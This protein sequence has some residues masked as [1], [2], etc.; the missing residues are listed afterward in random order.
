MNAPNIMTEFS[1]VKNH[2]QNSL[3]S[4]KSRIMNQMGMCRSV[5]ITPNLFTVL[6]AK[7]LGVIFRSTQRRNSKKKK[8]LCRSLWNH[9]STIPELL[10]DDMVKIPISSAISAT[11]DK[12][13]P[14]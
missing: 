1:V 12:N 9:I 10:S 4:P 14:R 7:R 6:L 2:W 11:D 5:C 3:S 13:K 8:N